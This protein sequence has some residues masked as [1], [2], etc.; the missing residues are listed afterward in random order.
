[1]VL[2]QFFTY[3]VVG[4]VNTIVGFGIIFML[5][6]MGFSP[7]LSNAIGYAIG[8]T[9]SFY[10]NMRYTFQSKNN[11]LST[12]VNFF[13]VLAIVYGMNLLVLQFLL[14]LINPYLAQII[15]GIV[16]TLGAFF[17]MK[18]FVFKT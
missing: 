11:T 7:V 5:M 2:K 6:F 8:A 17:L 4:L 18:I 9:L 14:P 1:M 13:V 15:A 16:Y 10:L 3:N 12:M